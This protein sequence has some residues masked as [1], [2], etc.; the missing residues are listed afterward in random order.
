MTWWRMSRPRKIWWRPMMMMRISMPLRLIST[1]PRKRLAFVC[2][3]NCVRFCVRILQSSCLTSGATLPS[4]CSTSPWW[5]LRVVRS[6]G[7][8]YRVERMVWLPLPVLSGVMSLLK[9]RFCGASSCL[10]TKYLASVA[11]VNLARPLLP[12]PLPLR[13][14]PHSP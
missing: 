12:R 10:T 4:L 1:C 5:L 13:P 6:T 3:D 2:V 14:W 9:T 7:K 8:V 11:R